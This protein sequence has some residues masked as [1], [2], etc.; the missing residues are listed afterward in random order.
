MKRVFNNYS[1]TKEGIL[2]QRLHRLRQ[3]TPKS[4]NSIEH[5]S[6][7]FLDIE[8]TGL[9]PERGARI[10]EIAICNRMGINYY[11]TR[12]NEQSLSFELSKAWS[13]LEKSVIVGHNLTFD[14]QFLSYEADRINCTG[15]DVKFIDTLSLARQI[16][17]SQ[18]T[19]TLEHLL[20]Y[21]K[22]VPHGPLHSALVDAEATR[23]LFWKL[24]GEGNIFTLADAGLQR[25]N[26]QTF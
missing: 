24:T 21:F 25:L 2:L 13:A 4:K 18:C 15:P 17:K 20:S 1:V 23:A 7:A 14:L 11:W 22:I 10:H 5:T 19:Y 16:L 26:W 9:Y 8:T 3:R 6:F 12:Q